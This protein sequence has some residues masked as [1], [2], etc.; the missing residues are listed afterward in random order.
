M[1]ALWRGFDHRSPTFLTTDDTDRTDDARTDTSKLFAKA[2]E[3][4]GFNKEG[5]FYNLAKVSGKP[6]ANRHFVTI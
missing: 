5:L 2:A 3:I 6:L 1:I 4:A